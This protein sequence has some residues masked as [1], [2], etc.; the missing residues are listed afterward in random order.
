[1]FNCFRSII[2]KSSSARKTLLFINFEIYFLR[3]IIIVKELFPFQQHLL[4]DLTVHFVM[5]V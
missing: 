3:I 4:R 5:K 1:M 2:L